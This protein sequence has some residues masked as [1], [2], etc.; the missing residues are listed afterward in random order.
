MACH[1]VRQVA[2][3][4]RC[5]T[6]CSDVDVDSAHSRCVASCA[7]VAK[8]SAKPLQG[9]NVVPSEDRRYHLAFFCVGTADADIPLELPLSA[10]AV[11]G[12][13][14]VVAV[15]AGGVFVS[16]C[17]EEGRCR[18]GCV[19]PGDVV[20]LNLNPDGLLLHLSYLLF[21]FCVHFVPPCLCVFSLAVYTYYL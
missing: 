6:V 18:L 8:L 21:N 12:T 3:R 4:L 15:S 14:S 9:F 10:S 19:L 7:F 2:E 5:V 17:S 11:P 16:S 20:H 13:P 1:Y